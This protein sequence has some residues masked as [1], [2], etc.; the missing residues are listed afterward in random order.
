MSQLPRQ[1]GHTQAPTWR[2]RPAQ[3]LPRIRQQPQGF[4]RQWGRQG[5]EQK[6][7]FTHPCR[8]TQEERGL[9]SRPRDI[10]AS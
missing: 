6:V 1:W 7:S 10:A 4:A 2:R 8:G 9:P 3:E 5:Q